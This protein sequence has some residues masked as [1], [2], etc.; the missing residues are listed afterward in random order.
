M[1]RVRL[2]AEED[3]L[4]RSASLQAGG[5]AQPLSLGRGEQ[6]I[7]AASATRFAMC[8]WVVEAVLWVVEC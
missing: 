8:G 5:L 4:R 2:F 3:R 1:S 7:D 6:L